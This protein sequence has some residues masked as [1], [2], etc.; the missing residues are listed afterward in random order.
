MKFK[1]EYLD[2]IT[3]P[4]QEATSFFINKSSM[5]TFTRKISEDEIR[6]LSKYFMNMQVQNKINKDFEVRTFYLDGKLFR[7]A[8]FTQRDR[9]TQVD[10][11]N[12]NF[13]N[14]AR[15]I[16]YQ[17]PLEVEQKLTKFMELMQINCGSFDLIKT[18][19]NEHVFLE[20]NPVGQFGITSLPCNYNLD[21]IFGN[22]NENTI[23]SIIDDTDF[24]KLWEVNKDKVEICKD[25]EYRY[26]CM[27]C[28]F[29]IT[30]RTNI[31]S[32]PSFCNYNPYE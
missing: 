1:R 2:I 15:R 21:K 4:I 14:P 3:K 8:M 5:T 7:M 6:A 28:R 24:C 11:R 32:K 18:N 25:C 12:Y 16:P 13:D 29:L 9:K 31:L 19:D 26:M 20:V 23:K 30:D 27:D 10:F 17:L 22:I